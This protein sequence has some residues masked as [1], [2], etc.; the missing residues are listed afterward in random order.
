[1]WYFVSLYLQDVLGFTPIEAGLAFLPMTGAII[2]TSSFA[3]RAASAGSEPGA[4]SSSA[5]RS[6]RSGWCSSR[7]V[8][9][10]GTWAGDVLVPAC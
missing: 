1:M 10:D 5:W 4:C 3:R 8:A 7:R 2:L 6:S 9:V